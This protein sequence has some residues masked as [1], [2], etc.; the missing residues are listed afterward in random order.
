M[1]RRVDIISDT[2][3]LPR[4]GAAARHRGMRLAYPR[5]RYHIREQLRGARGERSR[6]ARGLGNNDG[7][8]NYG[9]DV[10]RVNEFTYDGGSVFGGALRRGPAVG[11]LERCGVRSYASAAH[12]PGA[13][14]SGDQSRVGIA[15]AWQTGGLHRTA[16]GRGRPRAICRDHR[17]ITFFEKSSCV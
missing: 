2:P 3:W 9:P 10:P 17:L 16:Y 14:V 6:S 7:Y 4:S 13:W 1:E 5:R 12:R 15:A 11:E 8:Y